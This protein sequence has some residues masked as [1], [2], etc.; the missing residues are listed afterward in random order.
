MRRRKRLETPLTRSPLYITLVVV[1]VDDSV[2]HC[3]NTVQALIV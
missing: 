3:F 1:L 2:V